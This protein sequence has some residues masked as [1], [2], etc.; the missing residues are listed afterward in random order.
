[1]P[2][3]LDAI[4]AR[5]AALEDDP[6]YAAAI[7][8]GAETDE[9][10]QIIAAYD[11]LLSDLGDYARALRAGA[12][13]ADCVRLA[14]VEDNV[15]ALEA[16]AEALE[17]GAMKLEAEDVASWMDYAWHGYA[18]ARRAGATHEQC[19]DVLSR[20]APYLDAYAGA[21]ASGVSHVEYLE[22]WDAYERPDREDPEAWHALLY[23]DAADA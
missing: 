5:I 19:C 7:A 18:A 20:G 15:E 9:C 13:H 17:G 3:R 1:M 10:V 21:R 2:S 22:R 8:A 6:G 16:Y 23:P 4:A 14:R 11:G 12:E